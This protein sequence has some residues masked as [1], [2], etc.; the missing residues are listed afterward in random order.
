M[1]LSL[2]GTLSDQIANHIIEK[3][4]HLEI[5]PGQRILEQKIAEELG[6]SRS[7]VREAMR[8]LEKTGLVEII[9][10]CGARVRKVT[11]ESIRGFCDVFALLFGHVVRR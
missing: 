9:P 2:A 1:N 3:I 6:V 11:E 7:P 4:I 10:R 5:E 8:I